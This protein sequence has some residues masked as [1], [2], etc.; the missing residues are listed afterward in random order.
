MYLGSNLI[1]WSSR[2]QKVVAKS[3][4]KAEYS[5]LS[6]AASEVLWLTSLFKELHVPISHTPIIWCDNTGAGAIAQNPVFHAH[7]KHIKIDVH[8]VREKI[9]TGQLKVQFVPTNLQR[10]DIFTKPLAQSRFD[11]LRAKLNIFNSAR[12]TLRG[13]VRP[14][15]NSPFDASYAAATSVQQSAD[16]HT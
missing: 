13:D 12:F 14:S 4:T 9:V 10:V 11:F 3:S 15:N 6:Q 1:S 7:T 5:A 16:G 2:K 8:F